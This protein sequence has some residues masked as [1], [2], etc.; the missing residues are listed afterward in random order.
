MSDWS[1]EAAHAV[2]RIEE[3]VDRKLANA[4]GKRTQTDPELWF[5][6]L[7]EGVKA[8]ELDIIAQRL[9]IKTRELQKIERKS[10]RSQRKVRPQ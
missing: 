8:F 10:E 3:E 6:A 2:K 5:A 1:K 9:V 7:Q 4:L